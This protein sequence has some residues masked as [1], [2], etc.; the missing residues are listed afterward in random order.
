[1]TD[2]DKPTTRKELLRP[3]QLL[4]AAL[5]CAVFAGGVTAVSLGAFQDRATPWLDAAQHEAQR[6]A[7]VSQA[8]LYGLIAAGI[9]FIAV[10]LI[11]SLLLLA[12]K[13]NDVTKT[14]DKPVLFESDKKPGAAEAAPEAPAATD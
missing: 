13:P 3:A 10:L 14:I 5:V 1:M 7:V 2:N 11:M 12:V 9:A 4:I 6:Q 8:V